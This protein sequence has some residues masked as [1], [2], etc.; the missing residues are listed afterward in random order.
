MA[1]YPLFLTHVAAVFWGFEPGGYRLYLSPDKVEDSAPWWQ[2]VTRQ[3]E[4]GVRGP[5]SFPSH[6]S[7][8]SEVISRGVRK[9][10]S[11]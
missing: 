2:Q 6:H 3:L 5:A 11:V 10:V 1:F 4:D 7:N 9:G 8:P